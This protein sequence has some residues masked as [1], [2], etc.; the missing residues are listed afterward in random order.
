MMR[1]QEVS[2]EDVMDVSDRFIISK[3]LSHAIFGAY[4]LIDIM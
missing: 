3:K 4:L 2:D 1:K